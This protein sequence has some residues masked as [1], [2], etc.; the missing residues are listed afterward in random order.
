[1][2]RRLPTQDELDAAGFALTI[3]SLQLTIQAAV[4]VSMEAPAVEVERLT[5]YRTLFDELKTKIQVGE[6]IGSDT[7]QA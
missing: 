7:G 4:A 2:K 1:M 5:A 6:I 3:A